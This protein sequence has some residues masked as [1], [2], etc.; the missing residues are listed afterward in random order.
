MTRILDW[1]TCK[2]VL[3]TWGEDG[4]SERVIKRPDHMTERIYTL[5]PF[6][7]AFLLPALSTCMI[8]VK[9]RCKVV[10]LVVW[11]GH[12]YRSENK[13]TMN[14]Y[15][16]FFISSY[17]TKNSHSLLF[18]KKPLLVRTKH[19]RYVHTIFVHVSVF[20]RHIFMEQH[21]KLIYVQGEH[22][23]FPWLQIFITRK[24]LYVE[25][26]H[27]FQNVTQEVF[28][29]HISTLQHMHILLHGE[30]LIDNQFLST[31][32]PTCLQLL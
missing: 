6:F 2:R 16:G 25:Y 8:N 22:K 27:F 23:V 18:I 9:E 1:T 15:F 19:I 11:C 26:K 21:L 32:S 5:F 29:K 12:E 17:L 4:F 13:F 30:R 24:L 7:S 20:D 31:C 10:S 3:L 28:L 14:V